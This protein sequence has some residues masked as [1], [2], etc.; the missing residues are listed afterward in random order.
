MYGLSVIELRVPAL[1]TLY[2]IVIEIIKQ[3]L[4]LKGQL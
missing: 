3:G 2:L 1:P 4:K